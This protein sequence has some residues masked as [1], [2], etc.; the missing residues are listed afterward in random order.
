MREQLEVLEH[1]ANITANNFN[2]LKV[3]RQLGTVDKDTTLLVR[4]QAVKAANGG[5]LA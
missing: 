5:R 4:F 1:H 2:L 3:R